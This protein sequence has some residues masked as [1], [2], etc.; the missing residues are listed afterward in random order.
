MRGC[1]ERESKAR[2]GFYPPAYGGLMREEENDRGG[3]W[4][5][6]PFPLLALP[7]ALP[8]AAP[9]VVPLETYT[10]KKKKVHR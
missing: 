1:V 9:L 6:N 10:R 2:A 8:L 5:R 4:L 7:L 3:R